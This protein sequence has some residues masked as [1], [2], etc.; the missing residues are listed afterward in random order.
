MKIEH[1]LTGRYAVIV[2]CRPQDSVP[3][4]SVIRIG[5]YAPGLDVWCATIV[6]DTFEYLFYRD[7]FTV[8]G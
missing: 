2:G 7:E 4:G 3:V 6:G 8:I 5:L 1:P